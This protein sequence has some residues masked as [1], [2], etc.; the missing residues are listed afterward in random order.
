[1]GSV[2]KW[3]WLAKI[4]SGNNQQERM[5]KGAEVVSILK[6]MVV[7]EVFRS[8]GWLN[9]IRLKSANSIE[10]TVMVGNRVFELSKKAEGIRKAVGIII[11]SILVNLRLLYGRFHVFEK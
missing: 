2:F 5:I 9:S 11:F 8:R 10:Y 7:L 3:F 4:M 6:Y 1:M